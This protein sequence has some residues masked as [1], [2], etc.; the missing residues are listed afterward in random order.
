VRFLGVPRWIFQLATNS[1]SESD[2]PFFNPQEYF[3]NG[4]FR[5]FGARERRTIA[6]GIWQPA[7]YAG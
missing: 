5:T 6:A 1:S 7:S 2:K 4:I 3:P